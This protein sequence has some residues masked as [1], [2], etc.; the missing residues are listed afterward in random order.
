MELRVVVIDIWRGKAYLPVQARYETGGSMDVEPV[1]MANLTAEELI[2]AMEK[3]LAAGHPRLP[4]LTREEIRHRADPVLKATSARTWKELSQTGAS[5]VIG[6]SDKET[7]IDMSRLDKKGRWEYD[8]AKTRI[9][10]SEAP[11]KD[12]AVIIMDDIRSRPEVWQ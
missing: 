1:Y 12:I 4:A 6:W 11:L 9:L 3:V 7:R 2:V 5:Y 8:L 10:P